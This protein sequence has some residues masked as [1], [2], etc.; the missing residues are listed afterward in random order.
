MRILRGLS[1]LAVV[2]TVGCASRSGNAPTAGGQAGGGQAGGGQTAAGGAATAGGQATAGAQGGGGA[3]ARASAR[4]TEADYDALMKKVGQTNGAMRMKLMGGQAADAAK[5]ATQLAELFG[6]VERFWT[7]Q[8]KPD[9]VKWAQE[10]RM[11]STESAGAA[12][13]GDA[14]KAQQSANNLLGDCKQCHGTYRDG[15]AATGFRI[16]P[17]VVTP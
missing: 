11:F 9:A 15:D 2:L 7:Q 1:V 5:D 10:A 17:G 14:M 12:A 16:K 3:G 6:E 4:I 13:A 8:N